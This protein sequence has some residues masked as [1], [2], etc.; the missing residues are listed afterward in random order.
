MK[1][2]KSQ[3]ELSEYTPIY[4]NHLGKNE[5]RGYFVSKYACYTQSDNGCCKY[6]SL[7]EC[8]SEDAIEFLESYLKSHREWWDKKTPEQK[9]AFAEDW[10]GPRLR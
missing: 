7:R 4:R 5:C 9:K 2:I 1:P 10:N 8:H 6:Y 3:V